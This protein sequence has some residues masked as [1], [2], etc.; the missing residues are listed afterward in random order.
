MHGDEW[1]SE[2]DGLLNNLAS[3]GYVIIGNKSGGVFGYCDSS[4]DQLRSLK[5]AKSSPISDLI[6]WNLPTGLAGFS[7][8]G[9]GTLT[10]ASN[11]EAIKEF[12][13]AAAIAYHP[14]TNSL[15]E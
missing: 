9:G 14:T 10:S 5:W 2:T 4:P 3:S 13:I 11:S 1:I 12:N 7:M 15:L 6:D 8:G